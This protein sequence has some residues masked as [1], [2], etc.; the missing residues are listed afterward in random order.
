V[1]LDFEFQ[2][3]NGE[4]PD[5]LCMVARELVSG[6]EHCLWQG[7]LRRA[8]SPP[9]D[10]G[11][12]TLVCAFFASAE[13]GCFLELGWKRPVNL[14]CLHAEDRAATN[15]RLPRAK[16]QHSLIMACGRRG[17][18]VMIGADKEAARTLIMDRSSWSANEVTEIKQYCAADVDATVRLLRH[19]EAASEID[20]TYGLLRGRYT[21]AV[22]AME[23]V[24]V[25]I[26]TEMLVRLI[27]RWSSIKL[28]LIASIDQDYGVY[29]GTTFK[30]DRFAAYLERHGIRWPRTATGLLS[31]ADDTFRDMAKAYP[32]LYPLKELRSSLAEM[33][34]SGLTVGADGFN[35]CLLSPF[36]ARSGRN[37]PSNSKFIYGPAVWMRGLIRPPEGYGLAYIDWRAQEVAL[38]A[39]L[40]GDERMMGAYLTGDVYLG[41]AKDAGLAPPDAT[42]ET[43]SEVRDLCKTLVFLLNYGGGDELLADRLGVSRSRAA[44]LKALHQAT[45]A[46][47]WRGSDATTA[48]AYANKF[49][50]ST[51]GWPLH[52]TAADRPQSII[53][54]PMQSSG[55]DMMRIAAIAATEEGILLAAPVHDAFLILAPIDRLEH[56]I[57]RMRAIME[58]AGAAVTGGMPV[59]AD[60]KTEMKVLPGSRYRDKR[61]TKMWDTVLSLL[62]EAQPQ[63]TKSQPKVCATQCA[64]RAQSA[65]RPGPSSHRT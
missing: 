39:A 43:H 16:G 15:G 23:R 34:L 61:G 32:R 45:Y 44:A 4:R 57:E 40:F 49:I 12:D 30:L 53:N 8:K 48:S 60:L 64:Q 65:Q 28:R 35:R 11:S 63:I 6:R 19:M 1:V 10:I 52:V 22:A 41:F 5:P 51:F 59:F 17:I 55:G 14:L 42:A 29:D 20:W 9:F 47:F 62:P 36:G 26:D 33:R 56:D 54:Y 2:A 50:C 46:T 7:E 25:P 38:A 37:T 13:M 21:A 58:R 3:P 27:E 31:L 24:G 18:P